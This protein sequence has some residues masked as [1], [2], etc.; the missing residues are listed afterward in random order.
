VS[1]AYF[2]FVDTDWNLEGVE[3]INYRLQ[4][5]CGLTEAGS[6]DKARR[7]SLVLLSPPSPTHPL[8]FSEF[9]T[10]RRRSF[11]VQDLVMKGLVKGYEQWKAGGGEVG[12]LTGSSNVSARFQPCTY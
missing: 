8:L 10:R 12:G 9:G 5:I 6:T 2:K 7:K 4:S 1:E 3:G 11:H